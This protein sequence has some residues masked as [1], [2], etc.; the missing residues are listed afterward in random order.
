MSSTLISYSPRPDTTHETE[1]CALGNVY[2]FILDCHAKKEAA[3]L[4]S[5]PDDAKGFENDRAK[6][7]IPKF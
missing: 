4:Q 7:S 2:R 1:I 3:P 6:A 5:R